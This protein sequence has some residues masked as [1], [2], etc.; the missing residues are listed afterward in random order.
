MEPGQKLVQ[1]TLALILPLWMPNRY[2]QV[3]VNLFPS[4]SIES[5]LKSIV[6][7]NNEKLSVSVFNF[8]VTY[9]DPGP[10]L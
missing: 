2:A 8:L 3:I 5:D 10:R 9:K 6:F 1:S 4:A 7:Q